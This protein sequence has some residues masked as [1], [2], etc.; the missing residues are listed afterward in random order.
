[1]AWFKRKAKRNEEVI[2]ESS[3]NAEQPGRPAYRLENIQGVGARA[4]QEDSFT[5]MNALDEQLYRDHGMMFAVCDGMG[6]MKDGKVASETA[7]NSFRRS[8]E[9]LDTDADIAGQ[10]RD[11]VFAA[12]AEIEDILEGD[13]GSTVVIGVVFREQ[14][15]YASVGDSYFY[16]KRG[17]GLYRLNAEHNVCHL[18]YLENIRDGGFDTQECRNDP[19]AAALT[20]FLGMTGLSQVDRSV[21]PLRLQPGDLLLACSDGVGGVVDERELLEILDG[22]E[23]M[24]RRIEQRIAEHARPNQDNYTALIIQCL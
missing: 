21:R 15:Y 19:E 9:A 22:S 7:I 3:A 8:F 6:G 23:G 2:P 4:R 17:G 18:R 14:L 11:S 13:G 12:S 24:C 20:Q 5:F 16:L 10:L 1:M